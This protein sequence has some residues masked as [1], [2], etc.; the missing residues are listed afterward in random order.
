[1]GMGILEEILAKLTAMEAALAGGAAPAASGGGKAETPAK[2]ATTKKNDGPTLEQVQDKIRSLVAADEDN[3]TAIA[4]A[5]QKLG[6]K[7]AGDFEGKADKLKALFEALEG[8]ES[9][10]GSDDGDDDLL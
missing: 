10:G 7:R 3:K 6:G 9:G 2:K 1:M 8:I 5:I 4:G